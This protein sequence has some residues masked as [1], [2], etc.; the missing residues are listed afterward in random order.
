MNSKNT[1]DDAP[2]N[3]IN[4]WP[5]FFEQIRAR[6]A[7][8][9]GCKSLTALENLLGGISLAEYFYDI[10]EDRVFT[11]FDFEAFEKWADDRFNPSRLSNNSFSMAR[12]LSENEEQAFDKWLEWYDE[13]R[14]ETRTT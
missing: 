2:I 5:S 13:F 6:P 12:L 8:W 4:D 9:M 10:P 14:S 7:M 3:Q 1:P 11:G